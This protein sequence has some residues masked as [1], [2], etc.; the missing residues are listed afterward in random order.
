M[1][2]SVTV[3]SSF[4]CVFLVKSPGLDLCV[5]QSGV[6]VLGMVYVL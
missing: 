2:S 4:A 1:A 5:T 6:C 3:S